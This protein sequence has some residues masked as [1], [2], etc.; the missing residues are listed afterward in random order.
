MKKITIAIFA[1]SALVLGTGALGETAQAAYPNTVATSA[2]VTRNA[3]VTEGRTFHVTVRVNAGN[4]VV[5]G[6]KVVVGFAGKSYTKSVSDGRASFSIK[7]PSVSRSKWVTMKAKY[8]RASGSIFK[9]STWVSKLIRVK[10][11]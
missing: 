10:A 5:N 4:A 9:S 8:Y 3:S 2:Q 11:K 6:G 1:S 7:A